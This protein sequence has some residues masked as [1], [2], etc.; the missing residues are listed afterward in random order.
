MI[1]Q[2]FPAFRFIVRIAM[3]PRRTAWS[4]PS[5][6]PSSGSEMRCA[7]Q[8]CGM[9]TD[10]WQRAITR[11]PCQYKHEN[12]G[13]EVDLTNTTVEWWF[14]GRY[15]TVRWSTLRKNPLWSTLIGRI[16]PWKYTDTIVEWRLAHGDRKD[17]NMK[18]EY[19]ISISFWISWEEVITVNNYMGYR[20]AVAAKPLLV[21]D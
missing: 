2:H 7:R 11:L 9:W 3:R 4:V 20:W 5:A 14:D 12:M 13:I 16:L 10:A 18:W 17:R 1:Y 6:E 19:N 15:I 8:A 21:D